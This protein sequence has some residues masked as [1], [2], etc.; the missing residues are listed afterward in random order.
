[1]LHRLFL[2]PKDAQLDQCQDLFEVPDESTLVGTRFEY[3]PEY[4]EYNECCVT[5]GG[6]A[7]VNETIT[8][9]TKRIMEKPASSR[10][11]LISYSGLFDWPVWLNTDPNDDTS[12]GFVTKY[13]T[14]KE[15]DALQ[16]VDNVKKELIEAGV[17]ENRI[18]TSFGGY[19][20]NQ[21][22][23]DIWYVPEGGEIPKATPDD[24]PHIEGL[25]V[26]EFG[27]L[28]AESRSVRYEIF[29]SKIRESPN[30]R[31]YVVTY[32]DKTRTK[33]FPFRFSARISGYLT[34][35]LGMLPD[36]FEIIDGGIEEVAKTQFWIY[37]KTVNFSER[38]AIPKTEVGVET[39]LFDSFRYPH[40]YDGGGCCV[41]DGYTEEGKKAAMDEYVR[42]LNENP[43]LKAYIVFYGQYCAF[44]E[45]EVQQKRLASLRNGK[46]LSEVDSTKTILKILN[47]E[48]GNLI[49]NYGIPSKRIVTINGGHRRQQEIELWLVPS[50]GK[51]PSPRPDY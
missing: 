18:S 47:E 8:A 28:N 6:D 35:N 34:E 14:D 5:V 43:N 3:P 36:E 29:R 22:G 27:D 49:N 44:C 24:L 33:G 46:K 21:R 26:D 40:P 25:L 1:M 48:R 51:I 12:G 45:E 2:V 11:Y 4:E 7:A 31:G 10:L 30:S 17:S 15:A 50:D 42:L 9:L 38:F 41:I 13:K 16:Y 23:V 20:K 19:R 37:P 39:M 32:G